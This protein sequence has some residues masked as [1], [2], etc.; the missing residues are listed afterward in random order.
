M[1]TDQ[2]LRYIRSATCAIPYLDNSALKTGFDADMLTTRSVIDPVENCIIPFL[3]QEL[4]T[5]RPS[6]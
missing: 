1:G 3:K 5:A 6:R 4:R 2:T